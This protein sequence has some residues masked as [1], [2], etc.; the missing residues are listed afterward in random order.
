MSFV[1]KLEDWLADVSVGT[2]GLHGWSLLFAGIISSIGI[3]TLGIHLFHLFSVSESVLITLLGTFMP[4]GLSFVLVVTGPLIHRRYPERVVIWIGAWCVVATVVLVAVSLTSIVYQSS[5]GVLM[6]DIPFVITNHAT[7][8]SVLGVLMGAYDGQRQRERDRA[9]V[10]SDQLSILNRVLRHDIRNCVNVIQGNASLLQ[11]GKKDPDSAAEAI[12]SK[13]SE[14]MIVS[15][16]ARHLKKL[17]EEESIEDSNIDINAVV[18][19]KT[20][21]IGEEYPA[22]ELESNIPESVEIR[23]PSLIKTAIEELLENAVKHNDSDQ[24]Y[25]AVTVSAPDS[26][27]QT[28]GGEGGVVSIQIRDNGPGIPQE[29]LNVIDRGWET[30]LKHMDGLGLWFVHWVMNASNGEVTFDSD[31]T[32]GSTVEITLPTDETTV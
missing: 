17:V 3:C 4:M 7:I 6:T 8:G 23:A 22:V 1:S 14:L 15:D 20:S 29:Q 28:D 2:P 31:G 11:A 12:N 5:K 16:R 24:P 30:S 27:L 32:S 19:D 26:G 9:Q 10:L 13:A 25:V 18:Q 21:K